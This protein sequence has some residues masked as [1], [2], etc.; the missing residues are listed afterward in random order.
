MDGAPP[1]GLSQGNRALGDG[2]RP[3]P[4][5]RDRPLGDRRKEAAEVEPLVRVRG[6]Q[7]CRELRGHR[8]HG[9]AVQKG[10]TDAGHQVGGTRPEGRGAKSRN[11]GDLSGHVGH[12]GG[13]R[14]VPGEKELDPRPPA[15]LQK[16]DDLTAGVP[17]TPLDAG[18][19]EDCGDRFGIGR[20]DSPDAAV[21]NGKRNWRRGVTVLGEGGTA[22]SPNEQ[23][24]DHHL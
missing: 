5:D 20:H 2:L 13:A 14:F 19:S 11:P 6:V 7:L 18:I 23:G 3:V 17:E 22:R 9:R 1:A 24:T 16:D 4:I 10:V 15:R 12:E 21:W 8:Q